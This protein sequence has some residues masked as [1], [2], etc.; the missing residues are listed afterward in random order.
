MNVST[1]DVVALVEGP[2]SPFVFEDAA[3]GIR[4]FRG[5]RILGSTL[6]KEF[7]LAD[8][9]KLVNG[10]A[11]RAYREFRFATP[12]LDAHSVAFTVL[13]NINDDTMLPAEWVPRSGVLVWRKSRT[14]M[15]VS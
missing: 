8:I 10:A 15:L 1:A 13:H 3:R 11:T 5:Y 4:S 6:P 2:D 9:S 14:V 7:V 12:N